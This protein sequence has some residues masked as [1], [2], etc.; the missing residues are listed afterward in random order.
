MPAAKR[1]SPGDSAGTGDG[2]ATF[3]VM[4]PNVFG[5]VYGQTMLEMQREWLAGMGQIQRDYLAFLGERMRKDIEIAKRMAECR[6]VKAAM[7]LQTAFVETA[8]EDYME[9]AQKL[10]TLGREITEHCVERLAEMP[11]KPNGEPSHNTN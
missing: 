7:E 3:P 5:A 9:E 4:D 11:T 10:L 8:R 1:A 6:D 2:G